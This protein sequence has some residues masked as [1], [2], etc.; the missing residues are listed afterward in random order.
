MPNNL[1]TSRPADEIL[2]L[3]A[4][5]LDA[6]SRVAEVLSGFDL[7]TEA[8]PDGERH[9]VLR[10]VVRALG[11]EGVL[12]G[13]V[14]Q[15]RGGGGLTYSE[16]A[17]AVE[18]ASAH[19]QV[20]ASL[21]AFASASLGTVLTAYGTAQQAER[22]LLPL[23]RGEHLAAMGFTEPGGGSDV[24]NMATMAERAGDGFLLSGEK[25]WVDWA[26]EADWFLVF[27]QADPGR[28]AAGSP[29]SFSPATRRGS[30]RL[31]WGRSW[32]SVSTPPGGSA[33]GI[34]RWRATRS[35]VTSGMG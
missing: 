30:R 24:A 4:A 6:K 10:A 8:T 35:S 5:H 28:A 1:L 7:P 34:A 17:A 31:R 33:Y 21:L 26:T 22:Y 27:A 19:S 23:L 16:L 9:R 3:G 25:V 20:A 14:S 32:A 15:G 2:G 12:G 11:D 29:P 13:I 18:E